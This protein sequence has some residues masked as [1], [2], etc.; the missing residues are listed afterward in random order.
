MSRRGGLPWA[1][2][3]VPQLRQQWCQVLGEGLGRLREQAAAPAELRAQAQ[4]DLAGIEQST[5]SSLEGCSGGL[6]P[7]DRALSVY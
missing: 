2:T 5:L 7:V 3:S 1:P 4:Q 6:V